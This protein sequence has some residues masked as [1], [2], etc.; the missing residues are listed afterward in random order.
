MEHYDAHLFYD[1]IIQ[2]A[3]FLV[4]VLIFWNVVRIRAKVEKKD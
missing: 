1:L 3:N 2:L 4:L